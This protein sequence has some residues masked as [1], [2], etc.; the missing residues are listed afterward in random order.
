[1]SQG[2]YEDQRGQKKQLQSTHGRVTVTHD[3]ASKP[4]GTHGWKHDPKTCFYE[5]T[6]KCK[7]T[8]NLFYKIQELC[9]VIKMYEEDLQF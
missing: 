9:K 7:E 8:R 3:R 2:S 4:E 1:M 6:F 5:K